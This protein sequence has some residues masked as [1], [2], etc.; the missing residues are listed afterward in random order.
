MEIQILRFL[1]AHLSYSMVYR[2]S[3]TNKSNYL[4]LSSSDIYHMLLWIK[5]RIR[6]E[7][8]FQLAKQILTKKMKN[9]KKIVNSLKLFAKGYIIVGSAS[10]LHLH[11]RPYYSDNIQC[12]WCNGEKD[13]IMVHS[14]LNSGRSCFRCYYNNF[15]H[16]VNNHMYLNILNLFHHIYFVHLI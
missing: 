14:F 4:S 12:S 13:S 2:F 7:S 16:K 3:L 9:S 15:N 10:R 1:I 11:E 6:S 8:P 5:F